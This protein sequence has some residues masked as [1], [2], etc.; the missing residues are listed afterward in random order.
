MLVF[1][2]VPPSSATGNISKGDLAGNWAMTVIG[3]GGCGFETIHVT[4]TLN[5]NGSATNAVVKAHSV[6]CGD[7]TNTNQAFTIQSLGSNGSGVAAMSCMTGCGI[8]FQIQV[9]PD[10]STFNAVDITDPA[11]FWEGVAVHQ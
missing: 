7:T 4:F 10:R 5:A 9:S 2:V 8:G 11:N 6:G 3:Q 1:S